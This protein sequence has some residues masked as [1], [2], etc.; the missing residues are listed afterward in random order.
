MPAPTVSVV[1]PTYN[2]ARFIGATLDSVLAQTW[3]DFEIV[4]V[5]D[6]SDDA[7]RQ[8]VAERQRR[9]A[10]PIRLLEA[11]SGG[12]RGL[13]ASYRRGIAAARGAIVAFLE[14]D[15][16]WSPNYLATRVDALA[17]HPDVGVIV[18]PYRILAPGLR[19]VEMRLRQAILGRTVRTDRPYDEF[20]RLLRMNTVATFSC[21]TLRREL[22]DDLPFPEDMPPMFFDW[23]LLTQVSQHTRFVYDSRA[24]TLWRVHA[25]SYLRSLDAAGLRG[26]VADYMERTHAHLVADARLDEQQHAVLQRH[27]QGVATC[28]RFFRAPTMD[29]FLGLW[30]VDPRW[31]VSSLAS[32]T[33]NAIKHRRRA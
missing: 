33:I 13:V 22:V 4:V 19:G 2:G 17:R 26:R 10:A 20:A 5:D 31:A 6:A 18:A 9:G 25:D 27:G 24:H 23:W 15:D 16:L 1:V 21:L 32:V 30:R 14:H 11:G 7:T 12:R 3:H 29:T 8:V 28:V